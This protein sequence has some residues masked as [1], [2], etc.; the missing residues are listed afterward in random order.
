MASK[1]TR[2]RREPVQL[3][4]LDAD[5]VAVLACYC[6]NKNELPFIRVDGV[7]SQNKKGG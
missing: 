1:I 2:L 3:S 6:V 7:N 4:F 5:G